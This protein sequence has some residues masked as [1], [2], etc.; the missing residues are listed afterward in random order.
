MH[1]PMHGNPKLLQT[2]DVT[3]QC[4]NAACLVF[5]LDRLDEPREITLNELS[6]PKR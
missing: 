3:F 5:K 6:A 2:L 4:T 1:V